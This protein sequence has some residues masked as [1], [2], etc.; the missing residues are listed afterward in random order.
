MERVFVLQSKQ[1]A[2]AGARKLPGVKR[3]MVKRPAAPPASQ[4]ARED[5]AQDGHAA[6]RQRMSDGAEPSGRC[7]SHHPM[8]I[9]RRR[10]VLASCSTKLCEAPL[11]IGLALLPSMLKH[12]SLFTTVN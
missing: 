1:S 4:A 11:C 9:G 3:P 8:H 7:F 2:S 5:D 12:P 10:S 6:K